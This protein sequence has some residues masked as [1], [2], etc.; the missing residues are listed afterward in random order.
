MRDLYHTR[1]FDPEGILGKTKKKLRFFKRKK[2]KKFCDEWFFNVVLKRLFDFDCTVLHWT[3]CWPRSN[4]LRKTT[5]ADFKAV[6]FMR[7]ILDP[8]GWD[9]M[10]VREKRYLYFSIFFLARK[11]PEF[12]TENFLQAVLFRSIK[13]CG[14]FH[15][16]LWW[17]GLATSHFLCVIFS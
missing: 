3:S 10:H 9:F 5:F 7:S 12:L 2:T 16:F 1:Q 6:D 13:I 4:K 17:R 11:I 15:L 8:F 14:P